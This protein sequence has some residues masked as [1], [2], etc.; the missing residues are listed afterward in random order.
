MPNGAVL[1]G[2]QLRGHPCPPALP[3]LLWRTPPSFSS[4]PQD[5][6]DH[7]PLC[8]RFEGSGGEGR[9]YPSFIHSI[10]SVPSVPG[11]GLA[12]WQ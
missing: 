7:L 6:G 4:F 11:I 8:S 9:G 3:G 1:L 2:K 10:L 5:S 12:A